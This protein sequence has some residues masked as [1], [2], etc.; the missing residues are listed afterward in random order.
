MPGAYHP[1]GT[2]GFPHKRKRSGPKSKSSP[3]LGVTQYKR[4]GR[5]EAHIWIFEARGAK[6]HQRHLGS[7]DSAEAAARCYDRAALHLRGPSAELNFPL[8]EYEEDPFM[9]AHSKAD[10]ARFLDLLRADA[11]QQMLSLLALGPDG[12]FDAS[13]GRPLSVEPLAPR[14]L[15][16][17]G[18]EASALNSRAASPCHSAAAPS[19]DLYACHAEASSQL[20]LQDA[21]GEEAYA[22]A[23]EVGG[24]AAQAHPAAAAC[25][26]WHARAV[27]LRAAAAPRLSPMAAVAEELR[28]LQHLACPAT[29]AAAILPSTVDL[30]WSAADAEEVGS[31]LIMLDDGGVGAGWDLGV[32]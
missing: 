20:R 19:S 27:G 4:T 10:R 8:R 9:L 11:H 24:W 32:Y 31:P 7:Y 29:D 1:G 14:P 28:A 15:R 6:G 21:Y 30:A 3:Y 25:D 26:P 12:L 22:H 23:G 2:H 13:P 18:W 16:G 5:F 17:H